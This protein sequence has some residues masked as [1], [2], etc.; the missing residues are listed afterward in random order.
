MAFLCAAGA[1]SSQASAEKALQAVLEEM[2]H[3]L[4]FEV[5][6]GQMWR[7]VNTHQG[8]LPRGCIDMYC[9][10]PLAFVDLFQIC[11]TL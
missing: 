9:L 4:P 11:Q 8:E 1:T 6:N 3:V 7:A 10:W 2:P 5:G